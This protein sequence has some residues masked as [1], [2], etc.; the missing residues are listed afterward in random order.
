MRFTF[1]LII[2]ALSIF[3]FPLHFREPESAQE[4]LDRARHYADLY[5]WHAAGSL[6][7]RAER[8][9]RAAG[10]HRNELFAQVGVLRTSATPSLP[11]RSQ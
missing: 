2:A 5:N 8:T 10:D 6:F 3:A 4:M 11:E 9:F 1:A 7:E